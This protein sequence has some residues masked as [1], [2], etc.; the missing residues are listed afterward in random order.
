MKNQS[1]SNRSEQISAQIAALASLSM[2][3]LKIRWRDLYDTEPPPRISRELLTRAIAYRLQEQVFG[4]LEQSTRRLLERA[5]EDLS[6]RGRKRVAPAIKASSGTLLIR[7]WQG[8]AH[9]VTVLDE[10]V[11]YHG[12]RYGSLSEVARLITDPAGRGRCSSDSGSRRGRL[13]MEQSNSSARRCAIYTRK[14]SEEGLPAELQLAA[15]AAGSVRVL[16]QEPSGGGL[17]AG[18][19]LL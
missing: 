6:A 17:A 5:A 4:G 10:G 14:S 16:H 2:N 3:E 13:T 15:C 11:V 12:K 7:E 19:D 18:K 1:S 9:Q 8:A